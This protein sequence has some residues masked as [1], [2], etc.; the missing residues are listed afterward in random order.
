MFIFCTFN[1]HI[2][3]PAANATMETI[4]ETPAYMEAELSAASDV[5][6][7]P[8]PSPSASDVAYGPAPSPGPPLH[9]TITKLPPAAAPLPPSQSQNQSP[10]SHPLLT[11]PMAKLATQS[12]AAPPPDL[13]SYLKSI[14]RELQET[15]C[16]TW[17]GTLPFQ[18]YWCNPDDPVPALGSLKYTQLCDLFEFTDNKYKGGIIRF[19]PNKYTV[20]PGGLPHNR[21]SWDELLH[22]V[23]RES[24]SCGCLL[25]SNGKYNNDDYVRIACS[26]HKYAREISSVDKNFRLHSFNRDKSN[27]RKHGRRLHKKTN[28]GLP[29]KKIKSRHAE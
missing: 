26:R 19:D 22:D 27:N 6:H 4:Q 3:K 29:V 8:A 12:D 16:K 15:H 24:H 14:N 23:C 18:G 10:P 2:H 13:A 1:I 28:T 7:A 9:S 21:R 11:M 17:K 5:A 20:V 25:K